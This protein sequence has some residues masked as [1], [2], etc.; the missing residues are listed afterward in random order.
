MLVYAVR[1]AESLTNAATSESLNPSLSPLGVR[2]AAALTRRLEKVKF[3]A[4]YSSP[5]RRCLETVAELAEAAGLPIRLRPDLSECHHSASQP[6]VEAALE[7]FDDLAGRFTDACVCPDWEG[8]LVWPPANETTQQLAAR[9][10]K[11]ADYLKRRLTSTEDVALLIGHGSPLARLVE[12]WLNAPPGPGF[13]FVF[14]N[15]ALCVLRFADGVSSL[16]CL[17]ERS[18]LA[19][20]PAPEIAQFTSDGLY[21]GFRPP[22]R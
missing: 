20:L 17:N 9:M 19:D 22:V 10:N 12:A 15:A 6:A 7:S 13:R 2:Q 21:K 18:H 14:D 11:L 8:P 5:Y 3:T 1:H 16:L 4:I